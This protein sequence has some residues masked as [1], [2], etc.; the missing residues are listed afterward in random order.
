[1]S[2]LTLCIFFSKSFFCPSRS[3][4]HVPSAINV[5]NA[6]IVTKLI[7]IFLKFNILD[8]YFA[9]LILYVTYKKKLF[10]GLAINTEHTTVRG[11]KKIKSKYISGL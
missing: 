9:V 1:M 3:I 4:C 11:N 2:S 5:K 8:F 10:I 7:N 6:K